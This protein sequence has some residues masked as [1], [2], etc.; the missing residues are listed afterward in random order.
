MED[1]PF[2]LV[3]R[4]LSLRI[5]LVGL[6]VRTMLVGMFMEILSLSKKV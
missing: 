5:R 2:F 1:Q 3:L 4:L 6:K